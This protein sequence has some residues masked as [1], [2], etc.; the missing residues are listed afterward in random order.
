[1]G[2]LRISPHGLCPWG[3]TGPPARVPRQHKAGAL[4]FCGGNAQ[5]ANDLEDV[6]LIE[7]FVRQ[8]EANGLGGVALPRPVVGPQPRR[9]AIIEQ[10]LRLAGAHHRDRAPYRDASTAQILERLVRRADAGSHVTGNGCWD[11]PL[12]PPP[13]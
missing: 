4:F 12:I 2:S 10:P 11:L 1:V 6:S 13:A 7:R 9:R 8:F 5:G 3:S